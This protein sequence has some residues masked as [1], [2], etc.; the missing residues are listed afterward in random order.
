MKES[1][2]L[3]VLNC[4]TGEVTLHTLINFNPEILNVEDIM[5][6]LGYKDLECEWMLSENPI[7]I[8][9]KEKVLCYYK[10]ED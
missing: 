7:E 3:I 6:D 2:E 4:N 10:K 9:R 8:K 1:Y 5:K